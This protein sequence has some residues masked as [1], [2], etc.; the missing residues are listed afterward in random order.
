MKAFWLLWVS[1]IVGIL[2]GWAVT[3]QFDQHDEPYCPT[4]DSCQ[5]DYYHGK[6]R[7]T[8]VTP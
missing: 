4:E 3:Y 5:I 6:W 2:I 8:E 7:I 1:L